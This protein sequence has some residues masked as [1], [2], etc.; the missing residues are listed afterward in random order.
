MS[1]KSYFDGDLFESIC[2]YIGSA[3]IVLFTLGICFPWAYCLYCKYRISHTV[4]D[5]HR[6]KFEGN[7]VSF[8]RNWIVWWFLCF[9]TFGAYS[10]CL[11]N[12]VEQWKIKHTHFAD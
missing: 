4:I 12:K 6:L 9:V 7:G 1:N 10:L 11:M 5:G 3:C 2:I 8:L